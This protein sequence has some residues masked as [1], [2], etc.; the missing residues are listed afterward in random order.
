MTRFLTVALAATAIAFVP[1]SAYAAPC[2]DA[3]G[4]FVKCPPAHAAMKPAAPVRCRDAK[5]NFAKCGT[6]GA[7]RA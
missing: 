4:K 3:K 7:H 6:K 5:G 2:K 1:A